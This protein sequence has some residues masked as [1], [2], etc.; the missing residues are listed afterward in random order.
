MIFFGIAMSPQFTI[1]IH[2]P[3]VSCVL[4]WLGQIAFNFKL[5]NLSDL[6]W[7]WVKIN[8]SWSF[9][10]IFQEEKEDKKESDDMDVDGEKDD[11]EVRRK[12]K[13]YRQL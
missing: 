10:Y 11:A 6:F 13:K 5:Y 8:F 3:L 1:S 12:A 7:Q 9:F 2:L 4:D